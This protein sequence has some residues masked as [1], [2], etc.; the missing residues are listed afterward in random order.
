[1]KQLVQ[2]QSQAG[3][4]RRVMEAET[5]SKNGAS[6]KS[7]MSRGKIL[8][9][10]ALCL[11]T[12]NAFGQSYPSNLV[13]HDGA[14]VSATLSGGVLTIKGNGLMADYDVSTGGIPWKNAVGS[15]KEVVI[16]SGV[17]NIGNCAFEGC[18]QLTKVTIANTV[19]QIGYRAFHDCTNKNLH[20][21]IPKEVRTI[22]GEAFYGCA[23]KMTIEATT[24]PLAFVGYVP[25]RV[26]YS[27]YA[28]FRDS[29]IKELN[30]GRNYTH[31]G[32]D[33][34]FNGM[35][36]L[37]S[38]TLGANVTRLGSRA[39][40]GC[41]SLPS[42]IIPKNVT[43]LGGGAFANCGSLN[44]VNIVDDTN[45]LTFITSIF[46]ISTACFA[47]S[48]ITTV[49]IGRNFSFSEIDFHDAFRNNTG[50]TTL[51]FGEKVN[52][53]PNYTFQGCTSLA[54]I[55][56]KAAVPPAISANTFSGVTKTIPVKVPC[57]AAYQATLWGTAFSNL[58]Q[59]GSCSPSSSTY[60]LEVI[61]SD[62]SLGHA[63]SMSLA[64]GATLTSTW[65][66]GGSFAPTNTAQFGG[67]AI[68][69]A[70][71]KAN[72]VFQK[73]NDGN[74]DPMRIVDI[75]SNKTYT[76]L[77]AACTSTSSTRDAFATADISIYPNP[78]DEELFIESPNLNI[79]DETA[80]VYNTQGREVLSRRISEGNVLNVAHL[81][82]GV[83]ILKIGAHSSKFIK[84]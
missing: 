1:M 31:D 81:P 79:S 54:Q 37:S 43:E 24:V 44:D 67:K 11:L 64:S 51:T 41:S 38:L 68:L 71:A 6:P 14:N 84:K 4:G 20:I 45:K 34:P 16:E 27:V 32:G 53:I 10:I 35:N 76:A 78:V 55:T 74:T 21:T 18:A 70:T 52:S 75:T 3:N 42:I 69:I 57:L 5:I 29:G 15:I 8:L 80:F 56:S 49:Y 63:T 47:N 28:W 13:G 2:L 83:Y 66:F 48:P 19:T 36:A 72:S 58:V 12:V 23:G 59:N 46:G 25:E 50:L 30:L 40:E 39:F 26:Y 22:E 61:S 60:T 33:S 7:R 17:T 77:F 73:W 65:N 62:I 82:A 9:A